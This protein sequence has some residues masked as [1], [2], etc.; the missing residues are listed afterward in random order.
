MSAATPTP[1]PTPTDPAPDS[2]T[3]TPPAAPP[4]PG[5]SVWSQLSPEARGWVESKGFKDLGSLVGSYQN[6]EK[7]ISTRI[8][9]PKDEADA[10]GWNALYAK[11]GRP[12]KPDQYAIEGYQPPEGGVDMVPW[13]RNVGHKHGLS[14]RQWEGITREFLAEMKTLGERENAEYAKAV[15]DQVDAVTKAWGPDAPKMTRNMQIIRK[16]TGWSDEDATEAMLAMGPEKWAK[17]AKLGEYFSEQSIGDLTSGGTGG[18]QFGMSREAAQARI[19]EI[20]NSMDPALVQFRERMQS[21][22]TVAQR[23][24]ER[25]N[26]IASGAASG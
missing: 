8:A 3:S 6:A 9:M 17:L 18:G 14:Q 15:Q 22:D 12:E 2:A 16:I 20:I 21:G 25:L 19:N 24:W 13:F 7:A 10:E 23:E 4:D 5:G 11:L 1:T 26:R